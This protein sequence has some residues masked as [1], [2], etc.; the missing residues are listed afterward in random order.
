MEIKYSNEEL[1]SKTF[2]KNLIIG[3]YDEKGEFL[4]DIIPNV[5][6][7]KTLKIPVGIAFKLK[8]NYK[9]K[10]I[11][12]E[13]LKDLELPE[14]IEKRNMQTLSTSELIKVQTII[15]FLSNANVIILKGIDKLLNY[16]DLVHLTKALKSHMFNLKKTV[17]IETTSIDNL[18]TAADRFIITKNNNILYNGHDYKLIPFNSTIQDFVDLANAKGAKLNKYK[19]ESDLLKAIYRSVNR[20]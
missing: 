2:G 1:D 17:I 8:T 19:D 5:K 4:K 3:L 7:I 18:I 14:T 16:R 10:S 15:A 11:L 20:Q 13:M 12:R 6:T 9:N